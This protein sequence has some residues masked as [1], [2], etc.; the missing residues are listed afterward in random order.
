MSQPKSRALIVGV[1]QYI[2]PDIAGLKPCDQEATD[3]FERL[4][5]DTSGLFDG[6]QSV[7]LTSESTS[8]LESSRSNVMAH[9]DRLANMASSDESL[10]FYFS[11]HGDSI[12]VDGF[13]ICK[14]TRTGMIDTTGLSIRDTL[15]TISRSPARFK[16]VLLDCCKP[17]MI[18]GK[19]T[20]HMTESFEN[21]LKS[22]TDLGDEGI[23]IITSC[24]AEQFSY[25]LKDSSKSVFT[26]YLIDGLNG[27]IT[28][29]TPSNLISIDG[30]NK[31]VTDGVRGW[32]VTNHKQQVPQIISQIT[33][34]LEDIPIA[35][36]AKENSAS[37][38]SD[39]RSEASTQWL[40]T[41]VSISGRKQYQ[42]PSEA[43]MPQFGHYTSP[44][45]AYIVDR[46]G[47]PSRRVIESQRSAI[48]T[49]ADRF[50]EDF[51]A[52]CGALIAAE[53]G[54]DSVEALESQR[55]DFN[56]G[57]ISYSRNTEHF[58]ENVD[59]RLI[60][61][62]EAV[63]TNTVIGIFDR[64]DW[65]RMK[66]DVKSD[67]PSSLQNMYVHAQEEQ[68]LISRY[69]PGSFLELEIPGI[70]RGRDPGKVRLSESQSEPSAYVVIYNLWTIDSSI[71]LEAIISFTR[72]LMAGASD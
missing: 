71:G 64:F 67:N 8:D 62:A 36:A 2:D 35:R 55:I 21:A 19:S 31:Y 66:I 56:H 3:V 41:S 68:W 4:T 52:T 12:A 42:V 23:V 10:L 28:P 26:S 9:L 69:Y 5:D 43:E 44:N 72:D 14:D 13:L 48:N 61:S 45:V 32:S 46:Q 65:R 57:H 7:L 22:V 29:D 34:S 17:G 47:P 27:G 54:V 50:G 40:C 59:Y 49:Q 37:Q 1:S 39:L 11:G 70:G 16:M 51:L 24:K 33:G 15:K 20:Q 30:V 6:E 25:L 60:T 58:Y 18:V 38:V 63:V 53:D